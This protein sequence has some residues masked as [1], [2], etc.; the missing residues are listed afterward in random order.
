[1]ADGRE[2]IY[3]IVKIF[4]S[5]LKMKKIKKFACLSVFYDFLWPFWKDGEDE[6]AYKVFLF[7]DEYVNFAWIV[8]R[9]EGRNGSV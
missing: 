7:K 8:L 3:F 1:M 9:L 6:M 2:L 5:T 4:I